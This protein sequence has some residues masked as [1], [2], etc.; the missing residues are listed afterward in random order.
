MSDFRMGQH[1]EAIRALQTDMTQVKADTR[2]ILALL[3]EQKAERRAMVR[4]GAIVGATAASIIG[5]VF[6]AAMAKLGFHS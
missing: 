6:R 1:E 2:A 4:L 5:F 3:A